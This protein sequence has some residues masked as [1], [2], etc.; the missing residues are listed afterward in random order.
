MPFQIDEPAQM[1]AISVLVLEWIKPSKRK[2]NAIWNCRGYINCFEKENFWGH[3]PA[4]MEYS[5]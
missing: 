5:F 4:R 3:S 1:M 2:I